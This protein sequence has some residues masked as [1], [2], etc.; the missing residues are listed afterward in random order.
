MSIVV[1]T[2]DN[3]GDVDALVHCFVV[4]EKMHKNAKVDAVI[5]QKEFRIRVI[6]PAFARMEDA[7]RHDKIWYHMVKRIPANLLYIITSVSVLTPSEGSTSEDA[8]AFLELSTQ[9]KAR[10]DDE[11]TDVPH[12]LVVDEKTTL[13][14]CIEYDANGLTAAAA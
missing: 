8:I 4:Y 13:C 2:L 9:L 11:S 10:H 1:S 7:L 12:L 3:R 6:D 14:R 5:T